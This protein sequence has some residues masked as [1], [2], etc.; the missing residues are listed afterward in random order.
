MTFGQFLWNYDGQTFEFDRQL[1]L[2][3]DCEGI[4]AMEDLPDADTMDRARKFH[5]TYTGPRLFWFQEGDKAKCLASQEGFGILERV[6]ELNRPPVCLTCGGSDVQPLALP[7]VP[8]GSRRANMALTKLGVR[9]PGCGGQL[10][11]EGSG[12]LRLRLSPVTYYFDIDGQAFTILRETLGPRKEKLPPLPRKTVKSPTRSCW[13][14]DWGTFVRRAKEV[15]ITFDDPEL[16]VFSEVDV[17][18]EW[19]GGFRIYGYAFSDV[20]YWGDLFEGEFDGDS[21]ILFKRLLDRPEYCHFGGFLPPRGTP[22]PHAQDEWANKFPYLQRIIQAGGYWEYN[23]LLGLYVVIPKNCVSDFPELK[24]LVPI[25]LDEPPADVDQ[26]GDPQPLGPKG[27][28]STQRTHSN[29]SSIIVTKRATRPISDEKARKRR[30]AKLIS[31][32]P[33]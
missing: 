4:V 23:A 32:M 30:I 27:R 2:C 17:V 13:R 1:G 14:P 5:S 31:K 8:D 25:V 18:E 12:G 16:D 15:H 10:Q 33:D 3:Q 21:S 6:M 26:D 19:K 20:L 22:V 24:E 29:A 9:H 7:E 28:R 11:V